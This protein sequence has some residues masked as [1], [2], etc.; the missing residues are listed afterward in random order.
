MEPGTVV[1]SFHEVQPKETKYGIATKY[2]ISVDELEKQNPE[3]K[4]NLPVGFKLKIDRSEKA[5]L[6][7]TSRCV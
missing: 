6:L 1:Y 2:G 4:D 7:Y 3:I 5:C